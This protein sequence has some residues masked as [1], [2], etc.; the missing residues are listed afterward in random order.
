MLFLYLCPQSLRFTKSYFDL[1]LRIEWDEKHCYLLTFNI[2][3]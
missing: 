1:T 2:N 3:L